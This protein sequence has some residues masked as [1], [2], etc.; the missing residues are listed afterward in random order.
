M[1]AL[2]SGEAC[3]FGRDVDRAIGAQSF[4]NLSAATYVTASVIS[5]AWFPFAVMSRSAHIQLW[6]ICSR[7]AVLF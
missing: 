3:A 6:L 7:P 2:S 5:N 4:A 1:Q